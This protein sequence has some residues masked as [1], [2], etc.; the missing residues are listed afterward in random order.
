MQESPVSKMQIVRAAAHVS[1]LEATKSEER[2]MARRLAERPDVPAAIDLSTAEKRQA[3]EAETEE[4]VPK[5]PEL[6]EEVAQTVPE[7]LADP[8]YRE[9]LVKGTDPL[10]AADTI[11]RRFGNWISRPSRSKSNSTSPKRKPSVRLRQRG[12]A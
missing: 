12:P 1:R 4:A 8:A 10:K 7:R 6:E 5:E 11:R 9:Q 2:E 3:E